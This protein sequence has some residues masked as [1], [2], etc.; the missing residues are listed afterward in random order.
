MNHGAQERPFD[1][2]TISDAYGGRGGTRK[3]TRCFPNLRHVGHALV[4]SLFFLFSLQLITYGIASIGLFAALYKIRPVSTN[5]RVYVHLHSCCHSVSIDLTLVLSRCF[6]VCE[7]HE[8][9]RRPVALPAIASSTPGHCT[10][11]R[12]KL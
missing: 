4:R 8:T 7:V 1:L 10:T 5:P 2:R 9:V 6:P 3:G 12:I 11:C